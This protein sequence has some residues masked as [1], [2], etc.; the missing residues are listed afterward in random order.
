MVIRGYTEVYKQSNVDPNIDGLYFFKRL[1]DVE[2]NGPFSLHSTNNG[3]IESSQ[4]N[5]MTAKRSSVL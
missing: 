2:M 3:L 1:E 4:V 5:P